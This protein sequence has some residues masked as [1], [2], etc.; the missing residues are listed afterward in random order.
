MGPG[1]AH[2]LEN[3]CCVQ[4]SVPNLATMHPQRSQKGVKPL[5]ADDVNTVVAC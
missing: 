2:N 3:V 4:Y 1:G 5:S